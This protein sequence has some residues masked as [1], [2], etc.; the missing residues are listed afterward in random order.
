MAGEDEDDKE[1]VGRNMGG[2][3]DEGGGDSNQE[4]FGGQCALS[5]AKMAEN[6]SVEII[7]V[8]VEEF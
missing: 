3:D 6:A 4:W 8:I 1:G 5:L 7:E 2:V